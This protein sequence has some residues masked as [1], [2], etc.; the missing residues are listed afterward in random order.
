MV[1]VQKK[2]ICICWLSECE[3]QFQRHTKGFTLCES[4]EIWDLCKTNKELSYGDD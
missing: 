1:E 4:K 3:C 2:I